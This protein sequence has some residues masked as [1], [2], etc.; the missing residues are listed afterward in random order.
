MSWG[1]LFAL[2]NIGRAELPLD[3]CGNIWAAQ[4]RRPTKNKKVGTPRCGV[5]AAQRA[6]P[7]N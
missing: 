6:D 7:T 1:F 5:R 4:Q 3:R 2:N